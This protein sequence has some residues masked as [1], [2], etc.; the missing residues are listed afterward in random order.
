[1]NNFSE[2]TIRAR[3]KTVIESVANVGVVHNRLRFTKNGADVKEF[4][5][6]NIGG[7][8]TIRGWEIQLRRVVQAT[9]TF[10]G[11][12]DAETT[13]V[14]YFYMLRGFASFVDVDASEITFDALVLAIIKALEEDATLDAYVWERETPAVT[15]TVFSE[16][17]MADVLCHS[18]EMTLLFQEVL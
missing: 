16:V 10:Q 17:M 15:E 1:M 6:V 18:V 14:S 2:P 3:I 13:A 12:G 8:T 4:F 9:E 7:V 5:T 11:S